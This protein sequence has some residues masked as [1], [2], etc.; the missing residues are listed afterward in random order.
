MSNF[1]VPINYK[2]DVIMKYDNTRVDDID[3][4]EQKNKI[5]NEKNGEQEYTYD[6]II[7]PIFS[8]DTLIK[9][10]F[11][12]KDTN[13]IKTSEYD[14]YLNY[15]D[16]KGL[17]KGKPRVRYNIDY[18]NI[19]SLNRTSESY[20]NPLKIYQLNNNSLDIINNTLRIHVGESV[21]N[22][23]NITFDNIIP[24]LILS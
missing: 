19:D 22:D 12:I 20:N 18:I 1:T 5:V 6:D 11:N 15:L 7:N 2:R 13:T 23:F 21:L 17:S 24:V 16:E 10:D 14:P 4:I 9:Q 3:Y 8:P